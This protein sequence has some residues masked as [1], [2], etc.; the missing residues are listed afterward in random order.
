[1]RSSND[2]RWRRRLVLMVKEPRCGT[3][4]TRLAK[5]IGSVQ[6]ARWYRIQCRSLMRRVCFDSRWETWIAI[7][8]DTEVLDSRFWPSGIPRMKQGVGDLG[9]RMAGVFRALPPGPAMIA[10]TD[11]PGL[12]ADRIA[13]AFKLLGRHDAVFGPS[14]DGGYWLVGIKRVAAVPAGLFNGVRWSSENA[15][16]DSRHWFKSDRIGYADTL[17]DVDSLRDLQAVRSE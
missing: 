13:R 6:A 12:T 4:K 15:L 2:S 14:P 8:P 5:D 1:M 16:S 11:I 9:A 10:G 17:R 7:T 3:V